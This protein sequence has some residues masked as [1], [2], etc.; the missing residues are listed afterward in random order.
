MTY[1]IIFLATLFYVIAERLTRN[2][3]ARR[4]GGLTFVRCGRLGFS[5]Y[6][7]RR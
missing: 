5:Y 4:V 2:F 3:S 7:A 6:V 1:Q